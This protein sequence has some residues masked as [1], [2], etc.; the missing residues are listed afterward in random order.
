MSKVRAGAS[1]ERRRPCQDVRY[2]PR[3]GGVDEILRPTL[4]CVGEGT[5]FR[6]VK[7]SWPWETKK[8]EEFTSNEGVC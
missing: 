6:L 5:C 8:G 3:I 7:D 2:H 4:L 1:R